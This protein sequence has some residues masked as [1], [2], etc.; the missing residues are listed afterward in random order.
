[1]PF[2]IILGKYS[3]MATIYLLSK[4]STST[5]LLEYS[6]K[7]SWK[8]FFK[9][10]LFILSVPGIVSSS[11]K[12]SRKPFR[13]ISGNVCH[14]PLTSNQEDIF[15]S[16]ISSLEFDEACLNTW[17]NFFIALWNSL[18]IVSSE[19]G[20]VAASS[21]LLLAQPIE[22]LAYAILVLALNRLVVSL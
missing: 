5:S 12:S 2:C 7:N 4:L 16:C 17:L 20:S 13:Y 18:A 8:I 15:M 21:I 3:F 1:M 6:S 22:S 19:L 10:K 9:L 11:L 14:K